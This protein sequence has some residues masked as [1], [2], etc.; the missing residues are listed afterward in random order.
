LEAIFSGADAEYTQAKKIAYTL[1]QTG[2]AIGDFMNVGELDA[3]AGAVMYIFDKDAER[4]DRIIN[5]I[6]CIF[7]CKDDG[8]FDKYS[9]PN[10]KRFGR[11]FSGV[12]KKSDKTRVS[13]HAANAESPTD[14]LDACSA[15]L[16]EV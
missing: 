16:N 2:Y 14:W 11:V 10:A 7:L 4:T 12:G 5:S 6:G 15:L 1:V 13:L 8:D 3:A 9:R